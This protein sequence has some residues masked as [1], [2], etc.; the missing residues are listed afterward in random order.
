MYKYSS[1]CAKR[2]KKEMEKE[3]L[4]QQKPMQSFITPKIPTVSSKD[5][6]PEF[7]APGTSQSSIPADINTCPTSSEEISNTTSVQSGPSHEIEA[8]DVQQTSS[9]FV[10]EIA[11]LQTENI[12]TVSTSLSRS[13]DTSRKSIAED[14]TVSYSHDPADWGLGSNITESM[15]E[16][17]S[18]NPLKNTLSDFSASR[19]IYSDGTQ[20][21]TP[22]LF[23]RKMING[24]R[25]YRDWL[26][27]SKSKGTVFC[28]PCK[29][30]S[31]T[32]H[33]LAT[34]G[35]NDWRNAVSKFKDHE[36]SSDHY[37]CVIK[38]A[39]RAI[40]SCRIDHA[41]ALQMDNEQK[42]WRE[43]LKRVV[44]VIKFLG[45]R[46]L[47]FHGNDEL[48]GSTQNGCFLGC[49]EL[50]AQF[51]PFLENYIEQH[52]GA[53]SGD[54]NYMSSTTVEE[55]ISLM[56]AKILDTIVHE[57]K[58]A[59][60]Y[61]LIV[62]STPDLSLVDR[63]AVVVR[64][65]NKD[66]PVE[67]FLR[68]VPIHSHTG[69]HLE[70]TLLSVLSEENIDLCNCRGQSYDN[71]SNMSA[72]YNGLQARICA[73]NP[74]ALY[75]PCSAHSLNLMGACAADSCVTAAS[76]F[77][78]FERLCT[79]F[80]SST[81]RWEILTK[82]LGKASEDLFLKR[83]SSTRWSARADATKALRRGYKYVGDALNEL[84]NSEQQPATARSQAKALEEQLKAFETAI[85]LVVWGNILEKLDASSKTLQKTNVC[86]D[87][88]VSLHS[89]LEEYVQKM[90]DS[91]DTFDIEAK[92]M[93]SNHFYPGEET[94]DDLWFSARQKII[95]NT[96]NSII[97]CLL[98]ELKKRHKSYENINRRFA[99]LNTSSGIPI[100]EVR[101][102]ADNL[103][104]N[105][106]DDLDESF[107]EEFIQFSSMLSQEENPLAMRQY[108]MDHDLVDTFPNTE[109]ML[110][111]F[112]CI[113]IAN[114]SKDKSFSCLKRIKNERKTTMG[115]DR[116]LAL[117]LLAV[118]SDLVRQLDFSDLVD[119]FAKQIAQRVKL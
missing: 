60:Y 25:V 103:Q 92:H 30:Y 73:I 37:C 47:P 85:L 11:D 104:K 98:V 88:V 62:D 31:S 6:E 28:V 114:L 27:Y 9:A 33:A 59:K 69:E 8:A 119:D 74:L 118:E 99:I 78:F 66:G 2:K 64:Y 16:Y 117:S 112:L 51:D 67:R 94:D 115:Q 39:Q 110:R 23:W 87:E 42:Y 97:D 26:I 81:N 72:K 107:T 101:R 86:I 76:F 41:H 65:V 52:G 29:L 49:L 77:H 40:Q 22:D 3:T 75:V 20:L 95:F 89:S 14:I 82:H 13:Q 113:P 57:L 68:F 19:R 18:L 100:N 24:E 93:T 79:F 15:R 111:I 108:I 80:S 36:T 21:L 17:F 90:R 84:K 12:Q 4:K 35:F 50:I 71:A 44:A 1:G 55:F 5:P 63:L 61:S 58:M 43:V 106:P 53:G 54:S 7:E 116:F 70:N 38:F 48:F 32:S 91:F 45:E 46:G 105:Y 83:R 96:F 109:T 10:E 102:L 56:G 34:V